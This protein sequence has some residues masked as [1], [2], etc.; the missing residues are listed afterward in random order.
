[1]QYRPDGRGGENEMAALDDCPAFSIAEARR[2][3][4]ES[5]EQVA[6][7]KSRAATKQAGKEAGAAKQANTVRAFVE[8]CYTEVESKASSRP[9]NTRRVLDKDALQAIGARL[10]VDV[11]I[12]EVSK[13]TDKIKARGADQM[14]LQTRNAMKCLFAYA[15]ARG[16]V[17]FNPA[18]AVEARYIATARS[19]DVALTPQEIGKLL[20]GTCQSSMK[21]QHKLAPHL[22]ILCMVRKFELHE[23]RW[24]EID[25]NA[26]PDLTNA[27]GVAGALLAPMCS[28]ARGQVSSPAAP[29]AV[30]I[31][32]ASS[33]ATPSCDCS[34][35]Q[36]AFADLK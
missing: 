35:P 6:H 1:M 21:R 12:D 11:S 27:T 15:I 7:G 24:D 20:R 17:Q 33:M 28:E 25:K 5:R 13:I 32:P 8:I 19:R 9:H 29:P 18:A 4:E 36:A 14:A 16:K 3:R 30:V 23:A 26:P 22:L 2:R 10:P 34:M 31:V